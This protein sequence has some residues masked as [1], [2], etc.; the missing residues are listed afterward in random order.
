VAKVGT[1]NLDRTVSLERLQC[2]VENNHKHLVII[3]SYI[4]RLYNAAIIRLYGRNMLLC[5]ITII[6]SCLLTDCAFIVACVDKCRTPVYTVM[7]F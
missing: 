1:S 2:V 7:R 3:N 4:F 5:M 6:E